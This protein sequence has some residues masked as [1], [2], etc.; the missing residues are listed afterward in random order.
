MPRVTLR[1]A[2]EHFEKKERDRYMKI[3]KAKTA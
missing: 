2:T 3:G 1:Y